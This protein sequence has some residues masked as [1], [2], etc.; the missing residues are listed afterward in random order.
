MEIFLFL[1]TRHLQPKSALTTWW[2]LHSLGRR[3]LLTRFKSTSESVS[4]MLSVCSN[5]IIFFPPC[6]SQDLLDP[7]YIAKVAPDKLISAAKGEEEV[8]AAGSSI[9]SSLKQLAERRTDIFGAGTEETQIGKKVLGPI[10]LI[11]YFI[12]FHFFGCILDWRRREE[13]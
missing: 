4:I 11:S 2:S 3:S 10:A 7:D 9:G 12:L 6:L 13:G 8:F 5:I 1:Q